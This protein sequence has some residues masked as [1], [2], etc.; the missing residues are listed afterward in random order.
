[1]AMVA[2]ELP[3]ARFKFRKARQAALLDE[4]PRF[5]LLKRLREFRIGPRQRRQF[6]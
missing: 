1:M 6:E 4:G 2:Q 3:E 5:L